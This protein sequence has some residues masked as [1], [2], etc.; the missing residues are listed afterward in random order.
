MAR[1][2]FAPS[3]IIVCNNVSY[4]APFSI[5]KSDGN[6]MLCALKENAGGE[7]FIPSYAVID[8]KNTVRVY[9]TAQ[10]IDWRNGAYDVLISPQKFFEYAPPVAIVQNETNYFGDTVL[11][12]IY[13]DTKTRAIFECAGGVTTVEIP[14]VT[15]P[16]ISFSETKEG[17]LIV[18]SGEAEQ[19][20]LLVALYDGKFQKLLSVSAD[21]VSFSSLG[22][23][24]TTYI[25]DMLSRVKSTTF[26]FSNKRV[27]TKTEFSY[28]Q[29]KRYPDELVPYLFLEALQAGD[30]EKSKEYLA[31]E[32]QENPQTF[33]DYFRP[34][35]E[36][37][38]IKHETAQKISDLKKVALISYT[39]EPIIT[40]RV[41]D[42]TVKD[43]FITD[44]N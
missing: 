5:E 31:P 9:G 43:G 10:L 23:T 41:F 18:V 13:K 22:V 38:P 2:Y 16:K 4:D 32:M 30:F 19:Q 1:F 42:F 3:G 35:D 14:P 44:I 36:I 20:F 39:A 8:V 24:A 6:I 17:L 25:K 11:V 29:N 26:S 37:S 33:L 34:F 7:I 15:S 27:T 21:D 40:P 28:L 12:T